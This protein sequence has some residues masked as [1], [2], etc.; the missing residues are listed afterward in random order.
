MLTKSDFDAALRSGQLKL[1]I[2]GMSNCG[3][4]Y[5]SQQLSELPEFAFVRCCVDDRIHTELEPVLASFQHQQRGDETKGDTALL[6]K[7]SALADWMGQPYGEHFGERQRIYLDFEEKITFAA[8]AED[9]K[10]NQNFVLDTTGSVVNLSNPDKLRD[11]YLVV[12]IRAT[13]DMLESMTERY[14]SCPKP[15]AWEECFSQQAGETG[16]EALRRCYPLMLN[17]RL[18]IYDRIAH[19]SIPASLSADPS[20]GIHQW[21]DAIRDQL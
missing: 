7:V 17:T 14:F 21:L 13:P 2:V 4:S 5:R 18:K 19:V 16:D 11:H 9:A 15:V 3:K 20:V 1:C 10:P 6:D 12:H 8:L